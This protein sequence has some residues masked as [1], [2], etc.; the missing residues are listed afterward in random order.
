MVKKTTKQKRPEPACAHLHHC[1]DNIIITVND[2][3]HTD[4]MCVCV[5]ANSEENET[6]GKTDRQT[7]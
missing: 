1:Y 7:H 2:P 3:N 4:L 5:F 6:E